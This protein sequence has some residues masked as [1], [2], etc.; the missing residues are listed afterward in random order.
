M[1]DWQHKL[2]AEMVGR[3]ALIA[4]ESV[5]IRNL[6]RSAAG[7]VNEPGRNVAHKAGLNREILVPP[8]HPDCGRVCKKTLDQRVHRCPCGCTQ[9]R[10]FASG[11]VVLHWALDSLTQTGWELTEAG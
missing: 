9:P 7:T 8:R 5:S 6:T 1:T 3:F 4:T 10:D 2:S 11:R